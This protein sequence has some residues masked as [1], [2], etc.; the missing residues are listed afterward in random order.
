MT[1]EETTT[2]I[3]TPSHFKALVESIE[4]MTV[5]ELHE[6]VK[7]LEKKFGVKFGGGTVYIGDKGVMFTDT[8]GGNPH[9]LPKE[10]HREFGKPKKV[11]MGTST[12]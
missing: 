6:L 9:I 7:F 10:K 5:L 8:Y 11:L 2:P 12:S 3:E 1:D 4:K